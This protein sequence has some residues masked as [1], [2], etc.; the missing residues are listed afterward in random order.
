[1]A[2]ETLKT[3]AQTAWPRSDHIDAPVATPRLIH[4][5]SAAAGAS[6]SLIHRTAVWKGPGKGPGRALH[7]SPSVS[8]SPGWAAHRAFSTCVERSV[9]N[10][11]EP[12]VGAFRF[13]P[14]G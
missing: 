1:M 13:L 6:S 11:D 2:L 10:R 14:L 4:N 8:A 12:Q 7:P 3:P 5:V 9:E